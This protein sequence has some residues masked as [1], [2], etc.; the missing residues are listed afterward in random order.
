MRLSAFGSTGSSERWRMYSQTFIGREIFAAVW[1]L[2]VLGA[3]SAAEHIQFPFDDDL[4]TFISRRHGALDSLWREIQRFAC[5][6]DDVMWIPEQDAP[7]AGTPDK[8]PNMESLKIE[9]ALSDP[10]VEHFRGTSEFERLTL[11]RS[12]LQKALLERLARF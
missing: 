5:I 3:A 10:N 2:G 7:W 9:L 1:G 11:D 8:Y 12:S 4:R 6:E